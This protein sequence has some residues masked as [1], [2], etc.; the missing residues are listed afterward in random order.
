MITK[1]RQKKEKRRTVPILQ[2]PL[3]NLRL[4]NQA[5][6]PG[7]GLL[8][9]WL[10]KMTSIEVPAQVIQPKEQTKF[11]VTPVTK[12]SSTVIAIVITTIAFVLLL[13][14]IFG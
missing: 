4:S 14:K 2:P 10:H 3:R 7:N 1:S 12:I 13:K 9:N 11:T 8:S 5:R 6:D